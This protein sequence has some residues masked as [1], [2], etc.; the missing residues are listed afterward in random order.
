MEEYDIVVIG[1][2]SGIR[3]AFSAQ[4][5]GLKVALVESGPIGGTCLNRGCI[6]SKILT[7]IADYIVQLDALSSLGVK[8]SIESIDYQGIMKRMRKKVDDWAIRQG[9][10]VNET[11]G[12]DWF[13]GIGEF[14]NKNTISV[15]CKKIHAKHIFITSGSRPLIPNIKGLE[16]TEYVTSDE[17]FHLMEQPKSIII[18]GGG[19]VAAELGHFFSAIGTKV[20][21]LGRNGYLIKNEDND[22]SELLREQLS[23]RMIVE[24]NTEVIEV[25]QKNATKIAVA[26][27]KDT[28]EIKEFEAEILLVAAGRQSNTDLMKLDRAGIEVDQDGWIIVDDYLR[29]NQEGIWAFGDTLG[30]YLFRHVANQEAK[31]V[32]KNYSLILDGKPES[33]MK[34]MSYHAIARSVFSYPPIAAV[35]MTLREAKASGRKLLVANADYDFSVKGF[36]IAAPPSLV[37]IIVDAETDKLLGACVVGPY[38]PIMIQEITTM[39]NTPDGT[40]HPII[41][42]IHIHPS[43]IEVMQRALWRLEPLQVEN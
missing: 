24:T 23:K 7:S 25:K 18:I 43:L 29:T 16:D 22:V 32:W 35:G 36:A 14:V 21:I 27:K 15:N 33:E 3:I 26:K 19:Y 17:A 30:R 6:P 38:A 9:K 42:S 39:M 41:D 2:G 37:R 20:T 40:Y 31:L 34:K 4:Q 28:G 5:R 8:T 12:I 13:E 11:N 10:E 1:A